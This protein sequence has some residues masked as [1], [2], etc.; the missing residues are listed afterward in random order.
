MRRL[1]GRKRQPP[2]E[3]AMNDD[4]AWRDAIDHRLAMTAARLRDLHQR[5]AYYRRYRDEYEARRRRI[6]PNE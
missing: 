2:D 3:E 5:E 1:F 4:A 6:G